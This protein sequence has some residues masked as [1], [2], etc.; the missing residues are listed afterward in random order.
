M[1]TTKGVYTYE[2]PRPSVTTDCVIFGYDVEDGLQVLLV[3]RG[4]E[5]FKGCRALPGGFLNMDET[6]ETGALRELKEETEL[7]VEKGFIEQLDC[8]SDVNRDPRGRV[9]SIAYYALVPKGDVKGGDDA[10]NARWFPIGEI[11]A[12]AFDHEKI[13]D[14]ALKRLKERIL[15]RPIGLDLL[16]ETFTMSQL[17]GLYES[18][19]EIHLNHRNFANK[20]L[21]LG[22]L[23]ET[24]DRP[25]SV[26]LNVAVTYKFNPDKYKEMKSN[27]FRLEL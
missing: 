1:E 12:L 20:V 6:A 14:K 4:N 26:A 17:Q 8:F 9:I 23:E 3:E 18:I 10:R 24:G 19:L 21:K 16:P 22:I 11:P 15:F 27:G 25:K 13:L 7:D 2:Y 5:P